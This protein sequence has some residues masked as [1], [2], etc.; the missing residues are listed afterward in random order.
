MTTPTHVLL[1]SGSCVLVGETLEH[2]RRLSLSKVLVHPTIEN[3]RAV[4]A[5]KGKKAKV[6]IAVGKTSDGT[7]Y[8]E[9][10]YRD[11]KT[12]YQQM[13]TP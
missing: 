13:G 7:P 3:P 9:T 11:G 1:H 5:W 4:I 8:L 2:C 10:D 12:S 6:R